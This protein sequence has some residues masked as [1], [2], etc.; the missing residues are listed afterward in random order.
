MG[1]EREVHQNAFLTKPRLKSFFK[2]A[3]LE[4]RFLTVEVNGLDTS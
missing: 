4:K 3:V 2:L 1:E